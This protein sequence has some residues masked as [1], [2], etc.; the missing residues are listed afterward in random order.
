[1]DQLQSVQIE[2]FKAIVD[3]PIDLAEL[4]VLVGANNAGKSSV[5]QGLHFGVG[6]L[7]T[8]LLSGN[9]TAGKSIS[10]SLNPTQLIYSPSESVNALALGGKLLES[11]KS[12]IKVSFVLGSGDQCSVSVRKGRNR[13]ILVAVENARAAKR[14]ASLEEPFTVFSPGLAGISKAEQFVSDGVLLRTIARGD[15]NLVL[16]NILL[17]L[18]GKSEWEPFLADIHEIF[19]GLQFNVAFD[20][21]TDEFISVDVVSGGEWIPLE[22]VGTGVLQATQI[23]SYIHRFAPSLIV[24]DEP[25][26]HLHPNDQRLLCALL[27]KVAEDRQTQVLLTTHSRHVIDAIGPTTRFLWVRNGVVEPAT[28]DDEIGVL[29]DIGALDV[30]ERAAQP[31]AKAIVLTEDEN[32]RLLTTLLRASNFDLDQTVVLPYYGVTT[33][34]QLRPLI[35]MIKAVNPAAKLVLH[36]D[37]DYLADADVDRWQKD[38]RNLGVEPFVTTGVDVESHFV[39]LEHLVALNSNV[40]KGDLSAIYKTSL[41]ATRDDAVA[42]YVNGKIEVARAVGAAAKL[43]HGQLA[44]E[45]A[46]FVDEDPARWRH[47]KS[48]LR[49]V[50]AEFQNTFKQTLR[51]ESASD[52]LA[53]SE[54]RTIA[55]KVFKKP[56]NK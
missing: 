5:I 37:R 21:R 12:A 36:R 45:A 2:R 41:D 7:Q 54:L 53:N 13:N 27:R 17:R 19:P 1:M 56:G 52:H 49:K 11:I 39:N 42:H 46:K 8:I 34:K 15:A 26:S 44:V 20:E 47:G 4:N 18:W 24:L 38:V 40:S 6:L 35:K 25:D 31:N 16:R 50:R 3:A 32:P 55:K 28:L 14:L 22:L 23:L 33:I 43:N 30:K 29:L 9:W 48:L 10:T 51:I